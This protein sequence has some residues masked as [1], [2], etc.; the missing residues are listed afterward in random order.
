MGVALKRKNMCVCVCVC[1]YPHPCIQPGPPSIGPG[2][3]D[4]FKTSTHPLTVAKI[5]PRIPS[6]GEDAP[7]LSWGRGRWVGRG[8]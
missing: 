2:I 3:Q 1:V 6:V 8:L 4:W 7:Q 5:R